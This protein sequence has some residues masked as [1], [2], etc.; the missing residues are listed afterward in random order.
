VKW[1]NPSLLKYE[2]LTGNHQG[3]KTLSSAIQIKATL[4][5]V[6][7]GT[8]TKHSNQLLLSRTAQTDRVR[9]NN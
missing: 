2:T 4:R 6:L 9:F 5:N 8:A 7:E 1:A 3:G